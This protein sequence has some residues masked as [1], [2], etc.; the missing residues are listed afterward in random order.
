MSINVSVRKLIVN[1]F[2]GCTTRCH[3]CTEEDGCIICDDGYQ[4]VSDSCERKQPIKYILY[5]IL[6]AITK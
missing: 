3:E 2:A 4:L 1:N 6:L 5:T